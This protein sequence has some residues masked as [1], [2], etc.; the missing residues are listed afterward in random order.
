MRPD[1]LKEIIRRAEQSREPHIELIEPEKKRGS[2]LGVFSSSFNPPTAAHVE[3][4]RR[5]M[6]DFSLDE[7]LALAGT[8][9]ADKAEYEC[10]LEDRMMMLAAAFKERERVSVGLVSTAYYVDMVDALRRA[11]SHET[12]LHFI[13]GFDTFERVLDHQGKYTGRYFRKFADRDEALGYLLT[14]SFLIV[15]NRG[16]AGSSEVRALIEREPR[17]PRER[18]LSLDF[19]VDLAEQ[20]ASEVRSRVR[21]GRSISGLVPEGVEYYIR[22][23][24]LYR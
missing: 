8:A 6:D 9:N 10:P 24:N 2:R 17:V 14:D 19:P 11:Y 22:Q 5:A 12:R 4:I 1:D 7:V 16:G 15:A 3:L 18:V 23:H 21:S 20:S 13:L